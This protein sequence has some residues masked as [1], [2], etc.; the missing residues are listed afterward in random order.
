MDVLGSGRIFI[1]DFIII[2]KNCFSNK[3]A[4]RR[5]WPGPA[6]AHRKTDL[7]KWPGKI[8]GKCFEGFLM[9]AKM[10]FL[11]LPKSMSG[12][13]RDKCPNLGRRMRYNRIGRRR[14]VIGHLR[15]RNA[16]FG[17]FKAVLKFGEECGVGQENARECCKNG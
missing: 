14:C 12:Q 9:G 2:F 6:A 1:R 17:A 5:S 4:R 13:H 11:R 7:K 3:A 8:W 10:I 16:E 15:S